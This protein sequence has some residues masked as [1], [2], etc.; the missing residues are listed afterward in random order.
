MD[1]HTLGNPLCAVARKF[2][3]YLIREVLSSF[4]TSQGRPWRGRQLV[5]SQRA[6]GPAGGPAGVTSGPPP[7]KSG[8]SPQLSA[9]RCLGADLLAG[10]QRASPVPVLK[11]RDLEETDA[12]RNNLR[13]RAVLGVQRGW[14]ERSPGAKQG[15]LARE[16]CGRPGV[17]GDR[18][19]RRASRTPGQIVPRRRHRRRFP[20][21]GG[22]LGSGFSTGHLCGRSSAR[23]GMTRPGTPGE[24]QPAGEG[25]PE[26]RSSPPRMRV[27][28]RVP[29]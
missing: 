19:M 24:T 3:N 15:D 29:L 1:V 14:V 11:G 21:G 26:T 7:W 12:T 28:G 10:T 4:P 18:E 25:F 17:A 23:F 6:G 13:Y 20:E 16:E 27:S 2:H 5:T 22:A 9:A 8:A